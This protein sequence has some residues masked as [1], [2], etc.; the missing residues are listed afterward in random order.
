[1]KKKRQT[2]KP[3]PKID[4]SKPETLRGLDEET[5]IGIIT[6]LADQNTQLSELLQ[7][8][9]QE[10]YGRKSERFV[11]PNQLRLFGSEQ[12][13]G[14]ESS[15]KPVEAPDQKPKKKGSPREHNPRPSC[16]KTEKLPAK[17]RAP[18]DLVCKCCGK[19]LVKINEVVVSSRY[20]YKPSSVCFQQFVDDVL[21]CPAC[22]EAVVAGAKTVGRV[23]EVGESQT[24]KP[25]ADP[26]NWLEFAGV[27]NADEMADS[28]ENHDEDPMEKAAAVARATMR[29]S[30]DRIFRCKASPGL[31]SHIAVSKY[32]DHLPLYRLEQIFARQGADIARSTMCGW[33]ALLCDLLRGIY[34]LMHAK[35]LLSKIIKTDDTPV[36]VLDKLL[37]KK[38][39]IGRMWV[40]IGDKQHPYIVFHYTHGRGRAGP[41]FF[42]KGYKGFLQGDCFSGNEA[43]CAENGAVLVACNAHA[44][45]YFKKALLN[46]KSKSEEAL[47]FYQQ[48]FEIEREAREFQLSSADIKLMREQESKPI[49]NSLKEWL[50][51][52]VV[53]ALPKSAFGKAV[54]YCLNNWKALNAYLMDGDLS[55]DN[56]EAERQMKRIAM[57]RKA[58]LFFGSDS[59]GQRAE[60]LLS[61]IE[62]CKM[63]GIE[64]WSYLKDI[65]ETLTLD[66]FADL[67]PLLPTNWRPRSERVKHQGAD[68]KDVA[69]TA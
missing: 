23:Q 20:D 9:L 1:M 55:V 50:D 47:R 7:A 16:L 44:R 28:T 51:K 11:D 4:V 67:E 27:C 52:E 46:Y 48:L 14:S 49:L 37:K 43:I 36:K 58:W 59:G 68:V 35:L 6:R 66:P 17:K 69:K 60:V 56:N 15:D 63:H 57:G 45:R 5:F 22:D 26:V 31:L 30:A 32:C 38:I 42:L 13:T 25:A 8:F 61:I 12:G 21:A 64:P 18:E 19:P 41:K 34:D 40:Y 53:T 33:L 65:V 24:E 54:N 62:T 29:L 10:K 3:A 2:N 39:K